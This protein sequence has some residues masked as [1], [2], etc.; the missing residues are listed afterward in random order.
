MTHRDHNDFSGI[1]VWNERFVNTSFTQSSLIDSSPYNIYKCHYRQDIVPSSSM[2]TS[3]RGGARTFTS[4]PDLEYAQTYCIFGYESAMY[5]PPILQSIFFP[6]GN[7]FAQLMRT[8]LYESSMPIEYKQTVEPVVPNVVHL[9]WFGQKFK[10]LKFIEYLCLKSI[11]SVLQ[12]DKVKIHGDVEP[13]CDLWH[14]IKRHP[15][16]EWVHLD[17]PIIRYSLEH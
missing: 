6:R 5:E 16:I 2:A 11:L 3:N 14:K 15:K 13:D 12:P 17:R 9:I 10:G 1:I 8:W 4:K 7:Y